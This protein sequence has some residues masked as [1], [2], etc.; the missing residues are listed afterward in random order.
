MPSK[1]TYDPKTFNRKF[2]ETYGPLD[3]AA[4]PPIDWS[5]RKQLEMLFPSYKRFLKYL[6]SQRAIEEGCGQ[7]TALQSH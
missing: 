2:E 6:S 7:R 1:T 3:A 5:D 4:F